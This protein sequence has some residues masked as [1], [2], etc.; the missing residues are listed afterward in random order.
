MK[1]LIVTADIGAGHDLPAQ[2]L[3]AALADR[4]EGW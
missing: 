4:A 3:A 1:V 2:L